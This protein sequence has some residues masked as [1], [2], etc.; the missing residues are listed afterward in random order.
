MEITLKWIILTTL[1]TEAHEFLR[2]GFVLKSENAQDSLATLPAVLSVLCDDEQRCRA[3]TVLTVTLT[4][5][6]MTTSA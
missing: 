2:L 1:Q 6:C 5:N 4:Y 3:M